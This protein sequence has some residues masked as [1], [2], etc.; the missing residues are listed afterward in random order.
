MKSFVIFAIVLTV[1]YVIYY[2]IVIVQDLYGK[3]KE[4]KSDTETFDVSD[5]ADE[6]ESV[7]VTENEGGFS[8]GDNQYE[9]TYEERREEKPAEGNKAKDNVSALEKIQAKVEGKLEATCPVFSDEML[10]QDLNRIMLAK[11][12]RPTSRPN[13]AVISSNDKI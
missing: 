11:G 2:T 7:A 10:A 5:M 3:P 1:V 13:V 9:T 4:E 12:V 8:V 6:D